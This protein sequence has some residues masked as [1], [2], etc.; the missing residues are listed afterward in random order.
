[1][2]ALN[3]TRL[4]YVSPAPHSSGVGD[5]A[6]DFV[7]GLKP[8]F[9]E[10]TEF[11]IA[12]YGNETAREVIQNVRRIRELSR[13]PAKQGPVIVHFEQSASSLTTFWG[14]M[15]I[16]SA[17]VTATI[18]DAPQPVWWPFDVSAVKRHRVLHHGIHY[19]FRFVSN[20]LQR[21]M[22]GG[23]ITFALST[24]GAR[25]IKLRQPGADGRDS[26]LL[27]PARPRLRPL[28]E[29]PLA[30]GLFGHLYKGKGFDTIDQLRARLDDDIEI[31][32]AGRGTAAVASQKK[33]TVLGEVNGADE[34]R[35][36]D[37]I[38]ILIVP[39]AKDSIYGPSWAASSAVTRSFAYGTPILCTQNGAL[40]EIATEGGAVCVEGIAE[41][42]NRANT[43]VRDEES[44]LK[45]ADEVDRL[46]VERTVSRCVAPFLDAW[47]ELAAPLPV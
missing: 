31:V 39:Y 3:E 30:V 42:A 46:K 8:Y 34:D 13:T 41:I 29:R 32:V 9:R 19:P 26:R 43:V 22:C 2:A 38:R 45:L 47:A 11:W 25:N 23:R 44:L 40:A 14:A 20:A 7:A 28:T 27:I 37:S 35:F 5:Y 12:S 15:L 17:P 24:V 6:A 36:F 10:V 16:R 21:R 4:I 33:V 18:H 1:V